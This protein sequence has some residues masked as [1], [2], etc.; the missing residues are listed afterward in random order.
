MSARIPLR[1][2]DGSIRAWAM[3]DAE[4]LG[5][6]GQ[7]RWRLMNTGYVA[8]H[9]GKNTELMH[10]RIL[11]LMPGDKRQADHKDRDRLNNQRSNLRVVSGAT[12]NHQNRESYRGST[13]KYRGVSWYPRD[14]LWTAR[15]QLH[16][17][18]YFLGRFEDEDEAAR[19]AAEWRQV[20]MPYSVE[21]MRP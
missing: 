18:I 17:R 21:A 5:D 11:G 4:D 7:F 3:I 19:V 8:R 1:G 12:E 9:R 15:A 16:G 10:R 2:T 20:N 6:L 14:G 13:S